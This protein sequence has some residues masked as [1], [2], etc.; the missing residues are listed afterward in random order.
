MSIKHKTYI[1]PKCEIIKLKQA[2]SLLESFSASLEAD[3]FIDGGL[4]ETGDYYE[5][6]N[7]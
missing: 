1:A 6:D 2:H 3:D 5:T 4:L 7:F